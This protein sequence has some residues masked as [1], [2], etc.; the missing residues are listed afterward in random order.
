MHPD[1]KLQRSLPALPPL[2]AEQSTRSSHSHT[3]C[4]EGRGGRAMKYT[5]QPHKQ[6]DCAQ[7]T[8]SAAHSKRTPDARLAGLHL[9]PELEAAAQTRHCRLI[10]PVPIAGLGEL[11]ATTSLAIPALPDLRRQC[12]RAEAHPGLTDAATTWVHTPGAPCMTL[13]E[14]LHPS[15]AYFS[16]V[17]RL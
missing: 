3:S 2:A 10:L 8:E 12:T 15:S 7:L 13:S 11:L 9:W 17:N 5:Q 6:A 4:R 14:L 16:V 1:H